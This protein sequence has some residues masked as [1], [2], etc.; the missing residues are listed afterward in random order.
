MIIKPVRIEETF[1]LIKDGKKLLEFDITD[2]K[3]VTIRNYEGRLEFVFCDSKTSTICFMAEAFIEV[4]DFLK[5][6]RV[7]ANEPVTN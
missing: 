2:K 4:A 1:Q 6:R 5:K 7:C 3:D